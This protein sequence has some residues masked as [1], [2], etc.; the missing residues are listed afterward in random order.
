MKLLNEKPEGYQFQLETKNDY[1]LHILHEIL[2]VE[3][4]GVT[5]ERLVKPDDNFVVFK[6]WNI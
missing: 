5:H 3:N 4:D 6:V 1:K 2:V